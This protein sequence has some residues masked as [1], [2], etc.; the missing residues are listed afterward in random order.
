M[1]LVKANLWKAVL[2]A[3][4]N[5]PQAKAATQCQIAAN[6]QVL[7]AADPAEEEDPA[8]RSTG[9]ARMDEGH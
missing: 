6:V 2:E 5:S 1:V 4:A 9:P 8:C 3:S 7:C